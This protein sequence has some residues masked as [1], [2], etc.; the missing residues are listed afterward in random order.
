M[1]KIV[2][3]VNES[4]SDDELGGLVKDQ[5]NLYF[6]SPMP[7]DIYHEF[8][9]TV[10]DVYRLC[11]CCAKAGV[12]HHAATLAAKDKEYIEMNK[13]TRRLK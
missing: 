9:S 6:G 11:L 4:P 12:L 10:G 1:K 2:P 8:H 5:M 7:D 3:V 13:I